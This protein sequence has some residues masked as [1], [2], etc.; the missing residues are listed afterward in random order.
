MSLAGIQL[1]DERTGRSPGLVQ[2]LLRTA[3]TVPLWLARRWC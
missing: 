2:V 1:V 3:L